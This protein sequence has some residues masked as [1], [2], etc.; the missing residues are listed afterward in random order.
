MPGYQV[1]LGLGLHIGY[2]IEGAIG[3]YYKIDASYLSSHVR[4]AERLEGSTKHYGVPLLI[5]E[6]L[7]RKFTRKTKGYCRTVDYCVMAGNPKPVRLFTID[8]NSDKIPL[9]EEQPYMNPKQKKIQRVHD[10]MKRNNLREAAFKN[11]V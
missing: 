4:M 3:S 11:E 2:A 6:T 8:I 10:R 5:S 9:E 1:R 7:H